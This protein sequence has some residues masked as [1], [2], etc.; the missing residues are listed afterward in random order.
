M[1][2]RTTKTYG[3]IAK[4][5]DGSL[6]FINESI[7]N[8]YGIK[9]R[10]NDISNSLDEEGEQLLGPTSSHIPKHYY[11]LSHYL[12]E[13]TY[14]KRAIYQ[15]AID[16]AGLGWKLKA[17]YGEEGMKELE[18]DIKA[19]NEDLN[20]MFKNSEVDY[21][22][23]SYDFIEVIREDK[24]RGKPIAL[25][26]IPSKN[27]YFFPGRNIA[28][29]VIGR[30]KVYFKKY[31][32]PYDV[33][34]NTG[35]IKPLG[36]LEESLRATEFKSDY[37]YAPGHN[38]Y[39]QPP[40]I[41]ALGAI[42]GDVAR[43]NFNISW[44]LNFGAPS[45][46]VT[47]AGNFE[48]VMQVDG[49]EMLVE[50]WITAKMQEMKDN[51]HSTAVL[52]IPSGNGQ[53]EVEV[54]IEPVSTEIKEA[55]FRMYRIDNRDETLSAH[56][57]PPYRLGITEQGSLGGST[58]EHSTEIYKRTIIEP[59]Q[60]RI[61]RFMNS[62]IEELTGDTRFEFEFNDIDIDDEM[63]DL[64][65]AMKLVE[66]GAMTPNQLIQYF[67]W[68]YN[69]EESSHPAMNYHYINGTP[70]DADLPE[71]EEVEIE[72]QIQSEVEETLKSLKSSVE[73]QLQTSKKW[74]SKWKN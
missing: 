47:V 3:V 50:D 13:N 7:L 62:I 63:K 69:L 35:E 34:K 40:Y 25:N 68:K 74:W 53:G 64:D 14:H 38:Y 59:R 30:K 44:F 51:P 21:Q 66:K 54:K 45:H 46:L 52:T 60:N 4:G 18:N 22:V 39:G 8:K 36:S 58:A 33:N 31:K 56:S 19:L 28:V 17:I 61:Q 55:S 71:E 6:N 72:E 24:A 32:Y 11:D 26:H 70:I 1:T 37:E 12:E 41:A 49:E 16:I 10:D 65:M 15:K 2:K 27:I 57:V 42:I 48:E 5:K 43:R 29:Q 67:G 73:E 9:N 20:E 23:E